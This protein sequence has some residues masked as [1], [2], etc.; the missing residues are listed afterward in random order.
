MKKLYVLRFLF[1]IVGTVY[2][3]DSWWTRI[4]QWGIVRVITLVLPTNFS[5]SVLFGIGFNALIEVYTNH[6]KMWKIFSAHF[7]SLPSEV[8]TV[9]PSG[10]LVRDLHENLQIVL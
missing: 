1:L 2:F 3:M 4:I 9:C 8:L 6:P 5:G 10:Q 7:L